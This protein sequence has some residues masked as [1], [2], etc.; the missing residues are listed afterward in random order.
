MDI[1]I[2]IYIY[3]Y[4]CY[5]ILLIPSLKCDVKNFQSSLHLALQCKFIAEYVMISVLE[6]KEKENV[7]Y[8]F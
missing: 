2:Y 6:E 3:I 5:F 7:V 1:Y 8:M 4:I